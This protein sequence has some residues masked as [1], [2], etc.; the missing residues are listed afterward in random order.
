MAHGANLVEEQDVVFA[1]RIQALLE[2]R[3]I[4]AEWA[5]FMVNQGKEVQVTGA[6]GIVEGVA[7]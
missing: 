3:S 5:A 7:W 1:G 6:D 2:H 4:V